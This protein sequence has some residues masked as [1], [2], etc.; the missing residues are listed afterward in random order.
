[1]ADE[2]R[3][4][5]HVFMTVLR[6][7]SARAD[8][9][10]LDVCCSG[11]DRSHVLPVQAFARAAPVPKMVQDFVVYF[12]RHIRCGRRRGPRRSAPPAMASPLLTSRVLLVRP[13]R[14]PLAAPSSNA[15]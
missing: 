8:N 7:S 1:M 11:R 14:L 9:R 4:S 13:Q 15:V 2:V 5:M 3:R 12:Y 6:G 10:A